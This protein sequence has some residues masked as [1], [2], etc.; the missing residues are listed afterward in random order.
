M[1][2]LNY[3]IR[4]L[5]MSDRR[6]SYSTRAA[7][8]NILNQAAKQLHELGFR[9]MKP[10][11]LKPKHIESLVTRW[12]EENISDATLKNRMAHL[13]WW[14]ETIGK[15][16]LVAKDNTHYG[17]N[18][19]SFVA[20]DSKATTLDK[21]EKITDP[22]VRLSLELQR[23]FGLRREEAIKFKPSY[24]DKGDRIQL[25][26]SWAKGGRPREIP[27]RNEHQREILNKAHNLVQS[28]SLI[29]PDKRYIDQLRT[30]ERHTTR[31][32]MDRNHGLR[33]AYAQE[34]YLELTG[35]LAPA[36]G[37]PNS[38]ELTP[39]QRELDH[40]A[41]LQISQELGHGRE[42]ITAVYLGR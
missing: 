35:Y 4:K 25:K 20:A 21:L 10:T 11:S 31:T 15:P 1:R 13:R 22:Y 6:G 16:G 2:D 40:Q 29:P 3:G 32:G 41:R 5:V 8:W 12:K 14:A 18:Q 7:R 30:Y 26:A 19:R 33:H 27:I 36:V 28:R 34:R 23:A 37:G 42:E 24:A 17:I 9:N 39:E 38:K